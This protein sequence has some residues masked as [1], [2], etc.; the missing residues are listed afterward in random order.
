MEHVDNDVDSNVDNDVTVVRQQDFDCEG[1]VEIS[2]EVGIGRLDIQLAEG[3]TGAHTVTVQIRPD[4]TGRAPWSAGISGLL[5]WLGEQAG[6]TPPGNLTTEA[7][8][9]TVIDFTGQRLTVRTPRDAAL[10]SVPLM[11]IITAP[12]G[13][14]V[15]ARS[16]SADITVDGV[17]DRCTASTGSGQVRA[18][19]CTGAVDIRT[20]S[21]DV[22]LGSVLAVL[23]I[24]TGSGVVDVISASGAEGAGSVRTGSGDVR[25][26]AVGRD[27]T[28]RTGSGD[29]VVVDASAGRLELV[30][31]SGQ[32]RV[33]IHPGVLAEVDISSGSGQAHSDLPV[34]GQPADEVAGLRI[35]ARTGSGDALV[36][37]APS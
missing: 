14:S 31:G 2:A 4:P 32:L 37:S 11:V 6:T 5:T 16:G 18:Q 7:I 19:R 17:A 15:T 25:F 27:L 36:T 29:L 8:R 34:G 24:R 12:T 30:S 21:G 20:G 3:T 10:S 22:R 35:R 9:H 28:M 13:S 26:G 1:P 33:G 23:R